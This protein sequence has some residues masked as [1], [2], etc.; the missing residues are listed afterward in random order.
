MRANPFGHIDLRV[1]DAAKAASFYSKLLPEL[2]FTRTFHG[3]GWHVFAAEGELPQAAYFAFTE[4]PGHVPNAN[5]IAFWV[6]SREEV[7]RIAR[8]V[9][10]A[11]G[12]EI[13]GP[14]PQPYSSTYYAVFF[15]DP[16]G[17]RL[18]VYPR[19]N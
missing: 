9:R 1:R 2:G 16:S 5:R 18:E 13:E 15:S 17:N 19:L 3:G 10:E 12:L 8:V 11:G 4:D 7:D 14:E 6:P